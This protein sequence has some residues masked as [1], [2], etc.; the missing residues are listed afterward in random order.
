MSQTQQ[1]LKTVKQY[2][3][4]VLFFTFPNDWNFNHPVTVQ[5]LLLEPQHIALLL[6]LSSSQP[7]SSQQ[8]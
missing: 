1:T 7:H 3:I 5:K 8:H 2:C 6:P 4:E